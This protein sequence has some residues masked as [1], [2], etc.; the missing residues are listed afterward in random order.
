[1]PFRFKLLRLIGLTVALVGCAAT[2]HR[3]VAVGTPTPPPYGL[4][5]FGETRPA[6]WMLR[7]M[8]ADLN[9]GLAGHYPEISDTVNMQQFVRQQADQPDAAG[10]PGWWPGEH[11]GYYADGLF[12][13]A[14]LAGTPAQQQA[15]IARLEA[16]LAAQ[17]GSGY[18]GVYP[19]FARYTDQDPND[20]ELWTQSR[21]FQA[22]LA[23]YEATG[24]L[25]VLAAVESATQRTLA[26]Y[27]NHRSYFERAAWPVGGGGVSHGIGFA[28]T[29]EWLYRITG[30][31]TYRNGYLW[32]Y[33]DYAASNVR[34]DDLTPA[35]LLDASRP[36]YTHTPHIAEGLALPAIAHA[37]G[38]PDQYAQAADA[39]LT[40]L[41]RHS[42]P[43]GG[44][45][46]D[47]SVGGRAGSFELT[48]EYCSMTET[49]ASLNRLA[50]FRDTLASADLAER[51]ALNDAQG[52]R[53]H[54]AGRAVAYLSSDNRRFATQTAA[55]ADRLVYSASHQSAACC[56]LNSTRLLPY[57][58]EGMWLKRTDGSGLLARLYGP[59]TLST[60]LGTTAL[61]IVEQTDFPF[62]DRIAFTLLPAAPTSFTL[63][64]RIPDYAAGAGVTAPAGVSVQRFADRFELAGTWNAGDVVA[65][66]LA[67]AIR[68]VRDAAGETGMAWGPLLYAL[69]IDAV[70][71][72]GRVTQAAGASSTPVF[73]DTEFVPAADPP[74][75]LLPRDVAFSPVARADG[76]VLEPWSKPPTALVGTLLAADGSRPQLTLLPLGATVLRIAGF[77]SDELFADGFGDGAGSRGAPGSRHT[78]A[79]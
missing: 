78:D 18:I 72:P 45:V 23:W 42:N 8:Q 4:T 9:D 67:F 38:G 30:D 58:V 13:L 63:T 7:Q 56:S 40:K 76:D 16:V 62:S 35:H 32:L 14:W 25:R 36:W 51:I 26:A 5:R 60:T 31:D 37:Y 15:A 55:Y 33:A 39:V 75:Y 71:I 19:S 46:G 6:G 10:E 49:I 65:L 59:S 61:E 77:R 50:Q 12:R 34:D 20:G 41:A 2:A 54:T 44:P 47:E 28:D 57:Y 73:R 3:V 69:P 11:E 53:L 48:S 74:E 79:H 70:A 64:L 22:L 27:A 68:T 17:D 24:D 1:M 66:D 43:G 52:A 29:L 21:M